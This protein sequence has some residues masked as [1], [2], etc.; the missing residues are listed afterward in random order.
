MKLI[1]QLFHRRSTANAELTAIARREAHGKANKAD[2][3]KL[4]T[5]LDGDGERLAQFRAL[6][7]IVE[8]HE[9]LRQPAAAL[10]DAAKARA[11][12]G[13]AC[14]LCAAETRRLTDER[15]RQHAELRSEYIAA[16]SGERAAQVAAAERTG[17]ELDHGDLL[18][19]PPLDL[20]DYTLQAGSNVISI[21]DPSA[22]VLFVPADVLQRETSRRHEIRRAGYSVLLREHAEAVARWRDSGGWNMT[23]DRVPSGDPPERPGMPT[24]AECLA[25]GWNVDNTEQPAAE[26]WPVFA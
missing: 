14:D 8:R 16:Q 13:A 24:W 22:P 15:R 19:V 18:E 1:D 3:E 4:G 11:A 10:A 23:G 17:L 12:A 6:V 2:A 9:A 25:R 26:Q 20:D 5:L 21:A 7:T